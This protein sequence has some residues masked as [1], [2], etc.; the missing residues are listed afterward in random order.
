MI[1]NWY[2]NELSNDIEFLDRLKELTD[3]YRMFFPFIED[4]RREILNFPFWDIDEDQLASGCENKDIIKICRKL[5]L[6]IPILVDHYAM[7]STRNPWVR[8]REGVKAAPEITDLIQYDFSAKGPYKKYCIGIGNYDTRDEGTLY[9]CT[10]I[11][12]YDRS[13]Q[14][15]SFSAE[16][17]AELI[18]EAIDHIA[19]FAPCQHFLI[20]SS[21]NEIFKTKEYKKICNDFKVT[22]SMTEK[23]SHGGIMPVSTFF[24]TLKRRMNGYV[25]TDLQDG[26]DYLTVY[27]LKYNLEIILSQ[28]EENSDFEK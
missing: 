1:R 19:S 8:K 21:Q 6:P 16:K 24:S 15:V 11:D 17:N 4:Y 3:N 9:M 13:I 23:G 28:S 2:L 26:I 12:L 7:M 10:L 25:F 5:K 27:I 20:H 22:M 14:A 18:Q